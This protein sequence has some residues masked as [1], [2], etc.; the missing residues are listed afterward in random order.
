VLPANRI[1][2]AMK[3]GKSITNHKY[4]ATIVGFSL[5]SHHLKTGLPEM[6]VEGKCVMNPHILHYKKRSAICE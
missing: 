4:G 6:V 5:R 3:D 1:S 2:N